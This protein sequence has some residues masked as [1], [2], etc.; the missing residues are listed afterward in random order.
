MFSL[1][2]VEAGF[3]PKRVL[4]FET[5]LGGSRYKTTADMDRLTRDVVRRLEAVPGVTRAANVPFL[6]LEGGFGLGFDV[7]GRPLAQGEQSTGGAGWMYVS[8]PTS[9]RSR[10]RCVAAAW[11]A[12]ATPRAR[13]A[14]SSSTRRSRR[15]TGRRATP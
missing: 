15:D 13:R 7:V 2:S 1:R 6:P 9:R 3:N 14:S 11:S 8:T 10:S 5:S 12:S 4:S